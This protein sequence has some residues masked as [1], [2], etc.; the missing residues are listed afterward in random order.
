MKKC[1]RLVINKNAFMPQNLVCVIQIFAVLRLQQTA[2]GTPAGG[3]PD[4]HTKQSLTQT[5][6]TRRGINTIRSPDDEHSMLETCREMKRTNEYMKKC[7]RLVMNK[8]ALMSCN[9]V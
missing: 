4:Q 7:I 9:L 1:I 3:T 6:H 5:N 2:V 8:N